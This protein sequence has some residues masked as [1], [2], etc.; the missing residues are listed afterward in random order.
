MISKTVRFAL[1]FSITIFFGRTPVVDAASKTYPVD[2]LII[3]MDRPGVDLVGTTGFH[4]Y[5]DGGM[6]QAY[7]LVYKLL[8]NGIPVDWII[9]SGKLS[10]TVVCTV[11][12]PPPAGLRRL[13]TS[14]SASLTTVRT[15]R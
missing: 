11:T 5:Q 7:G 1:A 2:S 9:K 4:G 15:R 3:P 12:S 13:Q 8:T 10:S 6:L 14:R